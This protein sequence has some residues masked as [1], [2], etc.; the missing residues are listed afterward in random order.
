LNDLFQTKKIEGWNIDR[1][2]LKSFIESKLPK[3]Y[4]ELVYQIYLFYGEKLGKE[5]IGW[6]D[7][8]N[9]YVNHLE[10]INQIFP[11]SKYIHIIRN[12]KDVITSYLNVNELKE[13]KYKPKFTNNF[14][15]I[16][17]EWILNNN[18]IVEFIEKQKLKCIIVKYED[19]IINPNLQIERIFNFLSYE[20]FE[21]IGNFNSNKYFDEP[22]ITMDWKT[23][24]LDFIDSNNM[25]KF[26]NLLSENE[27]KIID[28]EIK[29]QKLN[30]D[31]YKL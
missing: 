11:N 15:E 2:T 5:V 6:G 13:S 31:F 14:L 8:N 12:P 25:N 17:N 24:L 30:F 19:L 22:Q 18:K 3:N 10:E 21:V 28:E 4:Q 20:S 27:I 16:L 23:K 26:T 29:L 1:E 9:Y 7:K